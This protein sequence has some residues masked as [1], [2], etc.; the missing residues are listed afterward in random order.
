[1]CIFCKI[2]DGEIPSEMI[3][4]DDKVVAFADLNAQAPVHYLIVPRKHLA[5]L[6]DAKDEDVELLGHLLNVAKKLALQLQISEKGYRIVVNCNGEGGQA[7][8]HLHFHLLG[9]RQMEWPP[10]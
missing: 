5:T 9:G 2:I 8:S 7:V 10:G 6:N 4:Q 1:M 3:Y